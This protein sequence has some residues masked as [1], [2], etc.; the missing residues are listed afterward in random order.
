[1]RIQI[2]ILGFKGLKEGYNLNDFMRGTD[3]ESE[4]NNIIKLKFF[5]IKSEITPSNYWGHHQVLASVNRLI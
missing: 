3:L 5:K 1:M 2:L 4:S